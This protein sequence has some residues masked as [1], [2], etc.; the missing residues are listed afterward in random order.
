MTDFVF[1][2]VTPI[3]FQQVEGVWWDSGKP[4]CVT[5]RGVVLVRADILGMPCPTDGGSHVCAA[6]MRTAYENRTTQQETP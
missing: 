2:S 6:C 3:P 1:P 5:H 4:R